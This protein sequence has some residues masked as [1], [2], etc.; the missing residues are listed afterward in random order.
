MEDWKPDVADE[1]LKIY[2]WVVP[3]KVAGNWRIETGDDTTITLS[4]TQRFQRIGGHAIVNG[5]WMPVTNAQLRGDEIRFDILSSSYVG[6]V[7]GAQMTAIEAP[8]AVRGW[9]AR[10]F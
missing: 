2:M 3:A 4:L 7:E 6:R 8:G 9:Q 10:K 5:N 1:Y